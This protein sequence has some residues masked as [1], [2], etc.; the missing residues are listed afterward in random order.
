[1][2]RTLL[3]LAALAAGFGCGSSVDSGHKLTLSWTD[4]SNNEDGFAIERRLQ[5]DTTFAEI[6]QVAANVVTYEDTT[7]DK[8]TT[9]C[10]RVRAFNAAGNSD[11][12]SDAMRRAG[13][14]DVRGPAAVTRL[15][16]RTGERSEVLRRY[17]QAKLNSSSA[18]VAVAITAPALSNSVTDVEVRASNPPLPWRLN[19]NVST[20][21]APLAWTSWS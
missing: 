15:S 17:F 14:C 3:A 20:L 8:G 7:V 12:T 11:Y 21:F 13:R 6:T 10:Y 9:Y 16:P 18:P 2:V 5:T 1:M 19:L 4:T